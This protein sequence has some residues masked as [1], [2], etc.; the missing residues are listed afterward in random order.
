MGEG[1]DVRVGGQAGGQ[2]PGVSTRFGQTPAFMPAA[3]GCI[4][5]LLHRPDLSPIQLVCADLIHTVAKTG[6]HLGSSLGV[7]ELS[8]ALH[9][10]F[11][12]PED[13]IIWDVGHQAYIHKML[14]GRRK[15]MHTIRQQGGLSGAQ[16]TG[17]RRAKCARRRIVHARHPCRLVGQ[18]AFTPAHSSSLLAPPRLPGCGPPHP[19]AS[20]SVLSRRT[21]PLAR[22]TAPRPSLRRWAWQWAGTSR[23]ART[24]WLRCVRKGGV[25]AGVHAVAA[26]G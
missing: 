11:N 25:T 3:A 21:T 20:P 9:Y 22:A 16:A 2:P 18:L 7:V 12:T 4:R 5:L 10:V 23:A 1:L 15:S 17:R 24:T 14:T 13:K 8:L 26:L 19:Q 6:G